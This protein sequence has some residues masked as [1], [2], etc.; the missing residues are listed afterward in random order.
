MIRPCRGESRYNAVRMPI[1]Q[2]VAIRGWRVVGLVTCL[3]LLGFASSSKALVQGGGSIRCRGAVS[4]RESGRKPPPRSCCDHP[5]QEPFRESRH[6]GA[7]LLSGDRRVS[8]PFSVGEFRGGV[9]RIPLHLEIRA[10]CVRWR[11]RGDPCRRQSG[12]GNR[13]GAGDGPPPTHHSLSARAGGG[14][15]AASLDDRPFPYGTR[16]TLALQPCGRPAGPARR[17]EL[18]EKGRLARSRS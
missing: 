7:E 6:A 13:D 18:A 5:R 14:P 1:S 17:T 16:S 8:A 15:L 4:A 12:P 3:F 11:R 10:L 2:P 9:D